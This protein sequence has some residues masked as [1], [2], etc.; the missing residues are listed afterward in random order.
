MQKI[1]NSPDAFVDEVLDGIVRAHPESYEFASADGRA[2]VRPDHGEATVGIVT[3]GGSGHLPLF[4]GYVGDGLLSGVAVGNVFSSPSPRQIYEATVA[5]DRGKGVLYL[6]GNYGGDVYNFGFSGD[7][8]RADGR[9]IRTVL[10]TDDLLSAPADAA[11]TRRGV[12]GIV[13]AF[14]TAGAAAA[15]GLSLDEVARIAQKTV[16]RTRTVGVGIAPTILPAAGQPTFDVQPGFMEIG[17]GIHG[18]SGIETVPLESADDIVARFIAHLQTEVELV[19]GARIAVLVNGLGATPLEELYLMYR[20]VDE[21]VRRLG[22]T[23]V[24][25]YIGEYATSLEMAGASVSL[26]A[27]DDELAEL[28]GDEA[29]SPFYRPGTVVGAPS[30]AASVVRTA[31]QDDDSSVEVMPFV[32]ELRGMLLKL[33]ERMPGFEGELRNLDAALG[34]GDLGIT[35]RAG[36]E[37]IAARVRAL[38]EATAAPALL[39]EAAASFASA[40]PSTFAAL[41]G[42]GLL[43][44]SQGVDGSRRVGLPEAVAIG[45]AVADAVSEKGGAVLGDKTMLD[46]LIPALD[47][48]EAEG[49]SA[50]LADRIDTLVDASSSLRSMKGR[51]AWHQGRSVGLADPGAVAVARCLRV[52]LEP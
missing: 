14:K 42:Y 12:A 23:I 6:F 15:R 49:P 33:G 48:I 45:R 16:D 28:L 11:E 4:L 46:V 5:C 32:S 10:G 2:L 40:N 36:S 34:D 38:P 1:I 13:F 22:A 7:L 35:V 29:S 39:R 21:A 41:V 30:S 43:Q 17:V 19:P 18:E 44:A 3:G 47:L 9:E 50:E 51:A 27:V 20:R 8:A 31:D 26:L 25:N 37:A 24:Y 52:L